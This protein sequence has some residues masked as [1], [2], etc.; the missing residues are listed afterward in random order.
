MEDLTLEQLNW[1]LAMANLDDAIKALQESRIALEKA[2]V[3]ISE[4][5]HICSKPQ[6][7]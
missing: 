4:L 7:S 3:N 5:K 2:L 1:E 6:Q